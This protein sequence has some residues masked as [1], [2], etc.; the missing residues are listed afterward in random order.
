MAKFLIFTITIANQ[1]DTV[2]LF[3]I[4]AKLNPLTISLS[5]TTV[6]AVP[7]VGL[8]VRS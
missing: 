3:S 1:E 7:A 5:L 6:A 8:E 2:S 4:S